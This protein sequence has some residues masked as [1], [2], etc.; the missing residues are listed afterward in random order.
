MVQRLPVQ[1]H[2]TPVLR[3]G[4][5]CVALERSHHSHY[6]LTLMIVLSDA[7]KGSKDV[8]EVYLMRARCRREQT[9]PDASLIRS[10]TTLSGIRIL[11]SLIKSPKRDLSRKKGTK[12]YKKIRARDAIKSLEDLAPIRKELGLFFTMRDRIGGF[13]VCGSHIIKWDPRG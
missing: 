9:H 3:S 11:A 8:Q 7:C 4:V 2:A 12:R 10:S 1:G 6:P 5:L 13:G